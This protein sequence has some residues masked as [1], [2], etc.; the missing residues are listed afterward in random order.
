MHTHTGLSKHM[1]HAVSMAGTLALLCTSLSL[2]ASLYFAAPAQSQNNLLAASKGAPAARS[3]TGAPATSDSN[4]SKFK[5]AEGSGTLIAMLSSG[6]ELG[7]CALKHTDVSCDISGYIARVTVK[8]TF[9]NPYKDKIE[10]LYTFPLSENGAVD[11]ML[12]KVGDRVVHGT[13]KKREEAREIYERAR[14]NGQT[15]SLLD[16]ERTN[17]FTQSV[18]NIEPGK[19]IEITI[20]YV[21]TLPFEKGKYSFAFPT[22]VGPRFNPGAPAGRTGSGW[23]EDTDQVP[24]ASR[25][26]PPVA[27]Q[28]QRAGH[29]ISINV[30][31]NAGMAMSDLGSPLHQVNIDNKGA[32]VAD[33]SLVNKNTIP[34]KDFVLSWNVAQDDLKSGYLTYKEPQAKE[35]FFTLMVVPPK[36]LTASKIAAKEMIFVIDCSGSQSGPPLDKCKET[37]NYILDH[38]NADD[39]F[40]IIAFSDQTRTFSTHPEKVS[41]AMKDRAHKFISDLQANGGTWMAPAV[42]AACKIPADSHRLRIVTFMTDGYVG[43]DFE[44]LSMVKKLRGVSRWFPFGTGN[45]VNRMLIDGIAREG[46]GEPDY[47]LL[48]TSGEAAGKKFYD[49]ISTPVLTDVKLTYQGVALKDVYP[50]DISDVWAERPLYFK[51][52]YTAGGAG[53]ITISGYT[54]GKPYEQ[55]VAVNFPDNNTANSGI[56]SL[57]ARAKVDRLMSEDLAGAQ[58]GA[59]NKELKE[60]I[61]ATALAHHIM[62]QY[63]SFVAVDEKIVN[64]NGKLM[65][66]TV[67]VEVPDGVSREHIFG[68]DAEVR[69]QSASVNRPVRFKAK[70]GLAVA[71]AGGMGAGVGAPMSA[72]DAGSGWTSRQN[73]F[74]RF[75][76]AKRAYQYENGLVSSAG[77]PGAPVA[78]PAPAPWPSVVNMQVASKGMAFSSGDKVSKLEVAE[79]RKP[80]ESVAT[81]QSG[82]SQVALNKLSASAQMLVKN[83]AV[84]IAGLTRKG[85]RVMVVIK[86]QSL[87]AAQ[88]ATLKSLGLEIET[89]GGKEKAGEVKGLIKIDKLIALANLDFVLSVLLDSDLK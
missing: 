81:R 20:K 36:R 43:N 49:R 88:M 17:I 35:G 82:P 34:N 56:A 16:Q 11:E 25:I 38:M 41:E 85:D 8:Q 71:G 62:T 80:A 6:K 31:L 65:T 50:R 60:E 84:K 14:A 69:R 7:Q 68:K 18:A 32:G 86:T 48:N 61:V 72:T 15:A 73:Y 2:P 79:E 22:V 9:H 66:V 29:D 76:Y 46:G 87:T 55:K 23:S 83:N 37:M 77:A 13:I 58:S 57:W 12:M 44:I 54:G 89:R 24:D 21:E 39:T 70:Q 53:T 10:A 78:S 42:E 1:R 64:K 4:E 19:E 74:Q 5:S 33:I 40:Q 3:R 59:V 27:A 67:P 47:V 51:G 45:S 75:P 28:G 30:H 52:K 63:T 26:T